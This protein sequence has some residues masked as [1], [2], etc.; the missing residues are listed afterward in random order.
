MCIPVAFVSQ[1]KE[2]PLVLRKSGAKGPL[3]TTVGHNSRPQIARKP[4]PEIRRHLF[5][6]WK[7]FANYSA[8]GRNW[9]LLN[10]RKPFTYTD[11]V[12]WLSLSLHR[13]ALSD[14]SIDPAWSKS[15]KA[16]RRSRSLRRNSARQSVTASGA[17]TRNPQ[18]NMN[19]TNSRAHPLPQFL[20]G[21]GCS[22]P[23]KRS[24]EDGRW[25]LFYL[26]AGPTP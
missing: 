9:Q 19:E 10:Q 20:L 7:R 4:K 11:L 3:P 13:A 8:R 26:Q 6:A 24:L 17:R 15:R 25:P 23:L 5:S 21:F 12:G 14:L 1:L 16:F 22:M 18:R 2:V